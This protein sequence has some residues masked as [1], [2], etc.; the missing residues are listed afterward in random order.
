[1]I[2]FNDYSSGKIT[3]KEFVSLILHNIPE[4]DYFTNT[5]EELAY[6]GLRQINFRNLKNT[7]QSIAK[8]AAKVLNTE[9]SLKGARNPVKSFLQVYL[10]VTKLP[11]IEKNK[12]ERNVKSD[13]KQVNDLLKFYEGLD[14]IKEFNAEAIKPRSQEEKA[15]LVFYQRTLGKR[16]EIVDYLTS[17]MGKRAIVKSGS[18][19]EPFRS[20]STKELELQLEYHADYPYMEMM[21]QVKSIRYAINMNRLD[22][23]MINLL[24]TKI[25]WSNAA[26]NGRYTYDKAFNKEIQRK[27]KPRPFF[28]HLL[29][30]LKSLPIIKGRMDIFL[31]LRALFLAKKWYGFYALALPQVE[32]IFTEMMQITDLKKTKGALPDKVKLMR[33]HYSRSDFSFDYFEYALP[34]ER[35]HFSHTGMVEN[36]KDKSYHLLLDLQYLFDVALELDTPLAKI[37]KIILE[38][39]TRF[40]DI[41][42]LADFVKLIRDLKKKKKLSPLETELDDFVY[43]KLVSHID[44]TKFLTNLE[45]D[46]AESVTVF[47]ERFIVQYFKLKTTKDDFFSLTPVEIMDNLKE[48]NSVLEDF[49]IM[50][51]E[52]LKVITDCYHFLQNFDKLFPKLPAK[53]I[54]EITALKNKFKKEFKIAE[55]LDANLTVEPL[56]MYL[57]K[58]RKFKHKLI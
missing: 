26:F 48:I 38:G 50:L 28:E 35:N 23:R 14:F 39:A 31:E 52:D 20:E 47:Q 42:D 58:S 27:V 36:P 40:H 54:A 22:Y 46:I 17:G 9:P 30:S 8:H 21:F 29:D 51:S 19:Y 41:G 7:P 32:G 16:D 13:L 12:L 37:S 44:L 11:A 4:D 49:G 2:D 34:T 56:D 53:A 10:D 6:L 5:L 33:P 55:L 25:Q 43:G 1:M 3:I 57:L 24:W 18:S 45:Q 15:Q